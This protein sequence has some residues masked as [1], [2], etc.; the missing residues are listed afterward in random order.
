MLNAIDQRL[1][2]IKHVQ[3]IFFGGLDVIVI[4]D[5]YQAPLVRN[6]WIFQ[7]INEGLSALSPNFWQDHI[8]CYELN[9]VMRQNDLVFINILNRF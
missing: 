4:S 8:K 3:N 2:S 1:H 9:I 5:F 7:K 6:K